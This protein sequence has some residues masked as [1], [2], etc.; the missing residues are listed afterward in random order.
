MKLNNKWL[1]AL[2]P[3]AIL[4]S[5]A[6]DKFDSYV[7]PEPAS[8]AETQYLNA[9][10]VLKDYNSGINLG[11][12]VTAS[13]YSSKGLVYGITSS[14]F[15]E[16][17]AGSSLNHA[18]LVKN[19][20][21]VDAGSVESF[22][23]SAKDAG[24]TVFGSALLSNTGNNNRYLKSILAD[25]IDP[26][27]EPQLVEMQ[28]Y[29]D[30]RC[31]RVR[32]TKKQS[33][34]WDNQFW[35]KFDAPVQ[36]GEAYELTMKIRADKEATSIGTQLHKA[37]TEYLSGTGF[38][39]VPFTTQWEDF[40]YTG[41]FASG[42]ANGASI[43]FNL[44]DFADENNYYFKDISLKIAD[45]E[46]LTNGDLKGSDVSSFTSKYNAAETLSDVEIVDGYSYTYL[47]DPN[48]T[49]TFVIDEPC[50]IVHATAKKSQTWDNQFW[51]TWDQSKKINQ[52]DT[53]EYTMRVR[54]EKDAVINE[55]QVHTSPS[56]YIHHQAIGAVEFTT[57]WAVITNKGTFSAS[58]QVGGYSIAF[59]LNSFAEEN[60]YMF[61]SISFKINGEEVVTNVDLSDPN[62]NKCFYNKEA[63]GNVDPTPILQGYS[64]TITK[65]PGKPLTEAEKHDTIQYALRNYISE[66]MSGAHGDV[67][68]WDVVANVIADDGSLDATEAED[69]FLWAS[70]LN[71]PA[72]DGS[73]AGEFV[74]LAAK[75]ARESF[76]ANGGNESDLKLFVNED[77]L[78]KAAKLNG[79]TKLITTW[80]SNKSVTI[81]GIS[82]SI[83]AS[84][85]ENADALS[86]EKK[87]VE[88]LFAALAKTNK[89]IRISGITL[90]Y[91]D[92]SGKAVAAK[93]MS[94]EQG[95]QMGTFYA[96]IVQKYKE[97]IP[98]N[99]QAG[100]YISNI[101][102]NGDTPCGLW[103]Q[104]NNSRK[105]QYGGFADGLQ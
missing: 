10:Q 41:T 86:A 9:Y 31:I 7:I 11:A 79:L 33:Q 42:D 40:K 24:Q 12:V 59:N 81:D 2:L 47:G 58:E 45:K 64:W 6:E 83:T 96:F 21:N 66:V 35:V 62:D 5:C 16:V 74:Q 76:V 61:S 29:D 88:D 67:K 43:A 52:G 53:W 8:L 89:L 44:N 70:Y 80:E 27:Y 95:K 78:E 50:L 17:S 30:T 4:S 26:N 14:N 63:E 104:S 92:A 22:V 19:S 94:V 99:Q 103:N 25:K 18:A 23:K 82:T 105:P 57:D 46:V 56:S 37:P 73:N 51:I 75:F 55:T 48:L 32:A 28:G 87:K 38:G 93:E 77:G 1:W 100:L 60:T 36:G 65:T 20:G 84:Y 90:D 91:K 69:K 98:A 85:S 34:P 102:D 71:G 97:L 49:E 68:S 13:D 54:A 15:N 101:F 72:M 39:N 3:A